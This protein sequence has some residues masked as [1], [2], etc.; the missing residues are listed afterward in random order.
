M[1]TF[2]YWLEGV[3]RTCELIASEEA[4]FRTWVLGDRS[5]TSIHYYD[6]LFEQ[7]IGDLHLEECIG[8][9]ENTLRKDGAF[10]AVSSFAVALR[11]LDQCI[12]SRSDLHD[13][14]MLL[15]SEVWAAFQ[16]SARQVLA[17]PAAQSYLRRT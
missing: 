1:F 9:F 3:V 6:E 2:E 15:A 8:Q 11:H 13:A 10:D 17:L 7:L 14:K 5:I 4:F 16:N 12:E